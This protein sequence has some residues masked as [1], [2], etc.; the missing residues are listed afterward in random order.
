MQ[1]GD[2]IYI[3]SPAPSRW[4][5]GF[6]LDLTRWEGHSNKFICSATKTDIIHNLDDYVLHR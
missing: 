1:E 3:L 5:N 4:E 2:Y 6:D